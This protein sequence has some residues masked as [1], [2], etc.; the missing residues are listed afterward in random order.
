MLVVEQRLRAERSDDS[1]FYNWHGG[2]LSFCN[3][4]FREHF[5]IPPQTETIWL[6]LH[7]RKAADRMSIRISKHCGQHFVFA[8]GERTV[9]CNNF[10]FVEIF[11]KLAPYI[12][13]TLYLQVKYEG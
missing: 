4:W 13:K 8:G 10:S 6:S 5:V 7:D 1:T 11:P 3:R 2:M 9:V 12:G